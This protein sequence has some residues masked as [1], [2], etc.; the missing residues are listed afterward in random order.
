MS[1]PLGTIVY[2]PPNQRRAVQAAASETAI[3]AES[4]LKRR[5]APSRVATWF[6]KA[7]VE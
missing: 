5:R 7:W 6:G 4:W 2:S 1:T 3:R